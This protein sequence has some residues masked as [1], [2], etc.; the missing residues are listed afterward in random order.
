MIAYNILQ[1]ATEMGHAPNHDDVLKEI[2]S[3]VKTVDFLDQAGKE[4]TNANYHVITIKELL[5][6]VPD[7]YGLA[8]ENQA[9]VYNGTYWHPIDSDVMESFLME[10]AI[11]MGAPWITQ[12]HYEQKSKLLKQFASTAPKPNRKQQTMINLAN[13]TLRFTPEPI[14]T[15]F[16]KQDFLK[17]QLPFIYD[18]NATTQIFNK[19][20]ERC[21]PDVSAQKL[22]AEYL[23]YVFVNRETLNLEKALILYG[24]GANGK[25]VMFDIVTALLGR[26]NITSYSLES[27]CD[28][29]GYHRAMIGDALLNFCTEVS[30]K[31]I[32]SS[33][34]KA[35]V[36][37]EPIEAR[38][39]YQDPV[40]MNK[41]AKLMFNTNE[42][43]TTSD[44]TE[45]FFR[46][47]TIIPFKVIIPPSERDSNLAQKIISSELSGVL[48]WVID[49]L[50]R[51]LLNKRFTHCESANNE[52]CQYRHD[53]DTVLSYI[54][55]ADI[56]PG[57]LPQKGSLL[58]NQ[59]KGHCLDSGRP[60]LG[61][62][63]FFRRLEQQSFERIMKGKQIH[64]GI[65]KEVDPLSPVGFDDSELP[66]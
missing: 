24:T 63:K 12:S 25:S 48:N 1:L 42:L 51:L 9:I 20:L 32:E 45:G 18:E 15:A 64:F 37:G 55:E 28:D 19:Y 4:P 54:D 8:W 5:K 33:Y 7:D 35:L 16:N 38:L 6:T 21:L 3:T 47:F 10:C 46:R 27:L 22:L 13:G 34:F 53:A 43:P 50:N 60:A 30:S 61:R 29:R 26:S 59:Y 58:Y 23:G 40:V 62:T 14:L 31:R 56:I 44:T 36:S 17:Y 52:L 2:L 11:K 41:Y 66:Y 65:D 49:G 39:P 57:A